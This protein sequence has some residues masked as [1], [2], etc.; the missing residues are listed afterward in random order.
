MY[1]LTVAS[2]YDLDTL[3]N[4]QSR[5]Q[6][7]SAVPQLQRNPA[8]NKLEYLETFDFFN[9]PRLAASGNGIMD[10]GLQR[11]DANQFNISNFAADA[12]SDWLAG[13]FAV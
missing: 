7:S 11:I 1:I 13:N 12:N 5:Q 8:G 6:T 2:A 10:P 4:H 9:Y 3:I